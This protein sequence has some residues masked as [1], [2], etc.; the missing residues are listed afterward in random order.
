M[1]K[2]ARSEF[3]F[4]VPRTGSLTLPLAAHLAARATPVRVELP[5]SYRNRTGFRFV[6]RGRTLPTVI[7]ARL[8]AAYAET[9]TH[10]EFGVVS[11]PTGTLTPAAPRAVRRAPLQRPRPR[12]ESTPTP[13]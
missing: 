4:E 3:C 13:A 10:A 9:L 1:A 6:D 8:S 5:Q 7:A 12:A 2:F 11:V